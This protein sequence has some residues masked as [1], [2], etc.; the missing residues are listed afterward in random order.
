MNRFAHTLT[1][2]GAIAALAVGSNALTSLARAAPPAQ[3][4]ATTAPD[5][6]AKADHHAM[7][8]ADYRAR[9]KADSK[10]AIAWLTLANHC[11]QKAQTYRMAALQAGAEPILR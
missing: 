8:A 3:S 9:A 2:L 11:D 6:Q 1:Q 10:R 5:L 4:V 7:M